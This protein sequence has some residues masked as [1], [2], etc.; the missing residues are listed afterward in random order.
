MGEA[1]FGRRW[2][3]ATGNPGV[4]SG[5][6]VRHAFNSSTVRRASKLLKSGATRGT[7][8]T[9]VSQTRNAPYD[10]L[11]T[12]TINPSPVDIGAFFVYAMGGG[13]ATA[14]AFTDILPYWSL[15]Q[16]MG[17]ANAGL[18]D[19]Y[20]YD[21]LKVGRITMSGRSTGLVEMSIDILGKTETGGKTF[22]GAALGTTLA[23]EPFAHSDIAFDYGA[24]GPFSLKDWTFTLDN[25]LTAD[26]GTSLTAEDIFEGNDR[27]VAFSGTVKLAT[28][29]L[30][31]LYG[32][33][34]NGVGATLFLSN[35]TVSTLFSFAA[36]QLPP[37]SPQTD[38][39]E[40]VL[41]IRAEIRG[42][43]GNEFTVTNDITP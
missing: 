36:M 18:G 42:T 31:A 1:A 7:R 8:A 5:A 6:S 27:V 29:V 2:A 30:T 17:T 35:S 9:V 32:V 12:L 40:V 43:T 22:A 21:G 34:K 37:Q 16:D 14:P 28:D 25:Q 3:V 19:C 15:L 39:P 26:F 20:Q 11:G 4:F 10:V 41:P 13:T 24:D 33:A 23:Y 38:G